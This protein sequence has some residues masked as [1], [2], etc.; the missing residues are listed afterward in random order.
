[1]DQ[2]KMVRNSNND[3]LPKKLATLGNSLKELE[4]QTQKE[5]GVNPKAY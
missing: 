1:M 2:V 4:K 3:N 5:K